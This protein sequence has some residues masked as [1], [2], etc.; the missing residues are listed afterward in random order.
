MDHLNHIE[1]QINRLIW[2][3]SVNIVLCAAVLMKV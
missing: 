3:T 1:R 2:M